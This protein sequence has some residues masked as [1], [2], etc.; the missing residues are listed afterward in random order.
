MTGVTS[1][2]GENQMTTATLEAYSATLPLDEDEFDLDIR[3]SSFGDATEGEGPMF[4]GAGS[5][6]TCASC[7]CTTCNQSACNLCGPTRSNCH[8]C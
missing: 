2:E 1:E 4:S 8:G 5:C 6:P 7:T 3:V